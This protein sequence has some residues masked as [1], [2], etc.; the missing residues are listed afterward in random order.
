MQQ[1][2]VPVAVLGAGSWGT[3]LATLL[4]GNGEPTRLWVRNP[5]RAAEFSARRSNALYLPGVPFPPALQ[6]D[7]DLE[8]VVAGGADILVA[9]PSHVFRDLLQRLA[10]I[11]RAGQRIAW[12]TKGLE[13]GTGQTL[14]R[15]TAEV[16]GA[17]LA[18]AVIS[19]PTFAAE[20]AAGLPTAVTVA[21]RSAVFAEE[22]AQRLHN[23]RFRVYVTGDVTGVQLGGSRTC[24]PS[25]P[26]LPMAWASVPTP[27]RPSSPGG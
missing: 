27:G 26:G 15:V 3:A 5:E 23:D 6:V 7:A 24:S 16:M 11:L 18:T 25:P 10:P 14:D 19:G 21:S 9:V 17:D 22:L 20:V 4:A 13:P 12:A 8:T 2:Q 1:E